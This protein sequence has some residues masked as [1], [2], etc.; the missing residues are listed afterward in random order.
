MPHISGA[1]APYFF[2]LHRVCYTQRIGTMDL[3]IA[4]ILTQEYVIILRT[5]ARI[6]DIDAAA[7]KQL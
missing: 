5:H 7:T 3:S 1:F 6:G 2:A 4:K